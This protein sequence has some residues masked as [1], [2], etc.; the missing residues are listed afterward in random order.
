MVTKVTS[1]TKVTKVT[2]I[3]KVTMVTKLTRLP[4]FICT[5]KLSRVRTLPPL[6]N[7]YQAYSVTPVYMYNKTRQ[8]QESLPQII[9]TKLTRLPQ[10]ICTRKL[11][12]VRRSPFSK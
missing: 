10:F 9:V 1:I 2:M 12:R 6:N 5:I 11:S 8:G 3:T 7:G 4:P